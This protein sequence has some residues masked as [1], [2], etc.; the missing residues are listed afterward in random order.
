MLDTVLLSALALVLI[1]EGLLPFAFPD[2]WRKMMQEAT[3]L[4]NRQ[5]RLVGLVSLTLGM[6]LLF[7]F[8]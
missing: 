8:Q 5:L 2:F 7:F 3:S 6:A 4:E 1:F